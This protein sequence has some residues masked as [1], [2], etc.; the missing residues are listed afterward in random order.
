MRL[1]SL[2]LL[3][4]GC[5][6]LLGGRGH[7]KNGDLAG[8]GM[9]DDA[10][11]P[12]DGS[13]DMPATDPCLGK[14]CNQPPAPKCV[15]A[16]TLETYPSTGTCSDGA[17]SYS[18]VNVTCPNGCSSA[19]CKNCSA[20]T[21]SVFCTRNHV[22]CGQFS[23]VD[24]CG[25]PRSADCGT[26]G[27][28]GAP[29]VISPTG[30]VIYGTT[31]GTSM[32]SSSCGGGSAPEQFFS[33]TPN[34]SGPATISTCGSAF[35]TV[36]DL[37]TNS[38]AD[39]PM[40]NHTSSSWCYMDTMFSL[41]NFTAT[42]GTTYYFA[43]DGATAAALGNFTLKVVSPQGT[44]AAPFELPANGGTFSSAF[45]GG[46]QGDQG[47]C[48]NGSGADRV[49]HFVP[50]KSGNVSVKLQGDFWPVSLYV[51]SGS[52]H[53]AEVACNAQTAQWPT[54]N[55]SF[56]ATAGTDYYIWVAEGTFTGDPVVMYTLTVTPP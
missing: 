13:S 14:V 52:C 43:V 4:S 19:A 33:W 1:V 10:G 47:S 5:T 32:Y 56:A 35:D 36:L 55:V 9:P 30:A 15:D 31:S 51:R 54:E 26:C 23:G 46:N 29:T 7:G 2:L 3:V 6:A 34:A 53:G 38:C 11:L 17:C 12:F 39:T 50:N 28:C 16:N 24:N 49:H 48:G 21:N 18:T 8:V 22:S 37:L 42:A 45:N 44:C 41:I 40:C 25:A 20:E 27:T